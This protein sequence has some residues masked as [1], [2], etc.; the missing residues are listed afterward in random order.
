MDRFLV[1]QIS[2]GPLTDAAYH[3][4]TFRSIDQAKKKVEELKD[5][6]SDAVVRIEIFELKESFSRKVVWGNSASVDIPEQA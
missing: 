4:F 1:R 2:K 5:N 3:T 6:S